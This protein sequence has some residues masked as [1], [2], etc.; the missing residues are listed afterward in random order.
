MCSSTFFEKP[1][2]FP[3]SSSLSPRELYSLKPILA[4]LWIAS[5]RGSGSITV[6]LN[7]VLLFDIASTCWPLYRLTLHFS[8]FVLLKYGAIIGSSALTSRCAIEISL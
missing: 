5:I 6:A 8:E 2:N 3:I 1:K 7:Q 4:F